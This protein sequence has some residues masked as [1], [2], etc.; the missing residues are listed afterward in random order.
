MD[1]WKEPM[2]WKVAGVLLA[3]LVTLFVLI[4]LEVRSHVRKGPRL[5]DPPRA[6]SGSFS[7][8]AARLGLIVAPFAAIGLLFGT[9]AAA[10]ALGV[11]V[12]TV[13]WSLRYA[14]PAIL[15]QC[16]ARSVTDRNL[17]DAVR[18]L[19]RRP[20]LRRRASWRFKRR[21][22]MPSRSAPIRPMRR[23]S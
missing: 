21:I 22:R 16:G 12:A 17:V 19:R 10:V 2:T 11:A 15:A 3:G 5:P 4:G 1:L 13:F 23:S 6:P 20:A 18:T 7:R 14:G 9:A 8:A